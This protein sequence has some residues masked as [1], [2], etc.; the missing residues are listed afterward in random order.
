MREMGQSA[1]LS[2]SLY[3]L[4]G[5]EGRSQ[6][7]GDRSCQLW[8]ACSGKTLCSCRNFIILDILHN[9]NTP[10]RMLKKFF[11]QGRRRV[12]AGGVPL[13]VR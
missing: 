7:N 5:I 8:F 12:E 2:T 11:Q 3:N 1:W 4:Q 9:G 13:G 6:C 10:S